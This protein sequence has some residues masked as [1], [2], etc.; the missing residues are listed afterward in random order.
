[1]KNLQPS[2]VLPPFTLNTTYSEQLKNIYIYTYICYI[3][4][5][6][7]KIEDLLLKMRFQKSYNGYSYINIVIN[8]AL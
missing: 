2:F 8:G 5:H 1:M 6:S 7:L 3:P 4:S